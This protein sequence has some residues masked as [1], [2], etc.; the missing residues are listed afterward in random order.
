MRR[1]VLA[2]QIV[3]AAAL[4]VATSSGARTT[5]PAAGAPRCSVREPPP[6]APHPGG[7]RLLARTGA[8][9][10]LLCRYRGLDPK[11]TALRLR[12]SRLIV[13]RSEIDA[14][15]AALNALPPEQSGLH[16]PMDDGSA[17]FASFSYPH[18]AD[19]LVRIGL[20]GCETVAGAHPPVRT[21]AG[22]AG[23]RLLARLE[24]LVP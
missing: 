12:S 22:P 10:L 3:A 18:G 14:V 6:I 23:A 2:L 20:R 19:A 1:I 11:A 16:C 9:T 4:A 21:A 24:R 7:P 13:D 15:A 8:N 17:I 5:A